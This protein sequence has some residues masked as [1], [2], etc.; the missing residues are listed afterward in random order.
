MSHYSRLYNEY[1]P[2]IG[3]W[4]MRFESKHCFFK[5]IAQRSKNFKNYAAM[6]ARRHQRFQAHMYHIGL[7]LPELVMPNDAVP[8]LEYTR[9]K[10]SSLSTEI[11]DLCARA[12]E[13][14][15]LASSVTFRGTKYSI[16]MFVVLEVDHWE[17]S[18]LLGKVL[19]C[20]IDST[21]SGDKV[22]FVLR[23]YSAEEE[24]VGVLT[25]QHEQGLCVTGVKDILDYL[26]LSVLKG[27]RSTLVLHHYV[28]LCPHV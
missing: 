16:G 18:Y 6:A 11:T 27:K 28:S 3:V 13:N 12:F 23:H 19:Q 26:P 2:L 20:A 10:Q 9:A 15:F 8:L 22:K 1:G 17:R 24:T 14:P 21:L 5:Q 4:A 7:F 25:L